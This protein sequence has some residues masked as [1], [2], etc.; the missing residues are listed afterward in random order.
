[1]HDE[2]DPVNVRGNSWNC[3]YWFGGVST[4]TWQRELSDVRSFSAENSFYELCIVYVSKHEAE[5]SVLYCVIIYAKVYLTRG[6]IQLR[7][8][9]LKFCFFFFKFCQ[10]YT[11]ESS[12]ITFGVFLFLPISCE[13]KLR[14][15]IVRKI[16]WQYPVFWY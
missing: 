13:R 10:L 1:M 16:F 2:T 15:E 6:K 12:I 3:N 9:F 7:R 8:Y 5:V 4:E 11:T 14:Q